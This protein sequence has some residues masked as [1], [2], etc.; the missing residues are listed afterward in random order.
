MK[1]GVYNVKEILLSTN[2]KSKK[3]INNSVTP[4]NRSVSLSQM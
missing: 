1:K 3:E 2:I 4:I